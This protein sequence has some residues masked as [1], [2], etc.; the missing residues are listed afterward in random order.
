[1][2]DL[3][4]SAYPN[5]ATSSVSIAL[6]TQS[7]METRIEI[8]DVAGRIVSVPLDGPL[9]VGTHV[10]GVDLSGLASGIYFYRISRGDHKSFGRFAVM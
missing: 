8:Y 5:P 2:A 1:M 6:S 7:T 4:H 10:I 9:G 3:D